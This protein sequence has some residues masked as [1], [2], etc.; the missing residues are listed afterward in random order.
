MGGS[1]RAPNHQPTVMIRIKIRIRIM[2]RIWIRIRTRIR[3]RIRS[4]TCRW[5]FNLRRGNGREQACAK[6]PAHRKDKDTDK[7]T[8]EDKDND[9][10]KDT[11]KDKEFHLPLVF[12]SPA[13]KWEGASVRQTTSPP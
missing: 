1:E 6:P 8:D 10:D 7:D 3:I 9:K 5:Y 4:F 11:D 2:I 13:W 12:Q